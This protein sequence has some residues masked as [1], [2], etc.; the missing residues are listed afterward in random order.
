MFFFKI[1]SFDPGCVIIYVYDQEDSK[2]SVKY[3]Y[4]LCIFGWRR[5]FLV[6]ILPL[7]TPNT[8]LTVLGFFGGSFSVG[9]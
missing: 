3:I 2:S 9:Q 4:F 7:K 1:L 6:I 8:F 5:N